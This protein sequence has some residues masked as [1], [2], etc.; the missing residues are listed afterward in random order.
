MLAQ[1]KPARKPV[2]PAF[3]V[4]YSN[5]FTNLGIIS[6]YIPEVRARMFG[7]LKEIC[8]NDDIDG[9]EL[10]FMRFPD[11]FK[12]ETPLAD[13]EAIITRFVADVRQALDAG[14]KP[15]RHRWLCARVPCKLDRLPAIGLDLLELVDAGL[16]MVNLSSSYF[17]FQDHDL[18]AV[19]NMLPEAA[20][21]LEMCHCTMLGKAVGTGGDRNL[22]LR[23][24]DHQYYT[25]AHMAYRRGADGVS[26]FNFVYTREHGVPGRGPWNEP[27]FHVLQRLQDP[28]WLAKQPQ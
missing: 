4:L 27:P 24:T 15:G 21:Y 9:L 3:K 5:D 7:F 28:G 26:L 25:T 2:K 13:R 12:D 16:D 11:F 14:A 17:T 23:T 10:D 6:P 20:V 19:R 1:V 22:F 18:A 8:E